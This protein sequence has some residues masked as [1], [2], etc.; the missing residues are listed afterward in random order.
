MIV[1]GGAG[2][3]WFCFQQSQTI[4]YLT[5]NFMGMQMKIVK[6]Q[7]SQE[8]IRQ[9]NKVGVTQKKKRLLSSHYLYAFA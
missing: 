8:E 7:A 6:L 4:T 9:S 5:D 2:I 1:I 3:S